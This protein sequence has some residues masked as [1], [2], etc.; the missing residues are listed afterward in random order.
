MIKKFDVTITPFQLQR[1]IHLYL[2][3][4]YEETA[5]RYP[6][7]YMY[8]GHN[9]FYNEDATYG[10]SWGLKEFLD[11]YEKKF[12]VVG[13][14]C[15]HQGNERLNEFCPYSA[16][17]SHFGHIEGKG[18]I[19]MDWVVEE[20]KPMIDKEYRTY[21]S[22]KYT[23]IAG[24]SMGG[25]M[26]LYTVM[27]YNQYFSKAACLSSSIGMCLKQLKEDFKAANIINPDTRVY[28][29]FG[30]EETHNVSRTLDNNRYFA[31]EFEKQGAKCMINVVKGGRHCEAS[32]E[33]ENKIYF[34]FLWKEQ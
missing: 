27:K 20:L 17:H 2:P 30:T 22:R 24:S 31:N 10:K 11:A 8:D 14:E 1:T 19:L 5:M 13:I 4:N 28:L 16:E 15:N 9:L 7:L 33:K 26:S 12:I 18:G 32:W 6:V 3:D 29:S 21:P 23:A 34:D 25:L